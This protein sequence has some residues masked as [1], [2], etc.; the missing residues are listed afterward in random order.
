MHAH[1]AHSVESMFMNEWTTTTASSAIFKIRNGTTKLQ[2]SRRLA[3]VLVEQCQE[4]RRRQ[5][6]IALNTRLIHLFYVYFLPC[7][8]PLSMS[9]CLRILF[10]LLSPPEPE[11]ILNGFCLLLCRMCIFCSNTIM[12][13]IRKS[14]ER[15]EN[16]NHTI[17]NASRSMDGINDAIAF[18]RETFCLNWTT[19]INI[20]R[21]TQIHSVCQ[22]KLLNEFWVILVVDW[23]F[24]KFNFESDW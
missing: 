7:H 14:I 6:S 22:H 11:P 19:S 13:D 4:Q 8:R 16:L 18:L 15:C 9:N 17:H 1:I 2:H 3:A 24:E 20:T 21:I 12:M 23:V 10:F 5:F